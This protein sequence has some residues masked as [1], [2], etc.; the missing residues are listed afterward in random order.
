MLHMI[1]D[2][3]SKDKELIADI[4]NSMEVELEKKFPKVLCEQLG[5][6]KGF[7][8]ETVLEEN[9]QPKMHKLRPVP[10]MVREEVSD[11]LEKLVQIDVI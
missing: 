1:L 2:P 7:E 5:K 4:G 10:I 8:H 9:A 11:E 6:L 3:D